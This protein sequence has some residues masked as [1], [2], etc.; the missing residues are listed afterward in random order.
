LEESL[1]TEFT[2]RVIRGF[3]F[4]GKQLGVL[5]LSGIDVIYEPAAPAYEKIKQIT[6]GNQPIDRARLYKVGT[7]DMFTFGIGYLSLSH[8][9]DVHYY[10]PEFIRDI[11][12]HELSNPLSIRSAKYQH[13]RTAEL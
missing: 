5:C 13:W 2:Q 10:I 6:I 11:L 7:I 1:L 9:Q 4:R 3:G 8:G 12:K